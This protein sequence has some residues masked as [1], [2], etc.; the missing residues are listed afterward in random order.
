MSSSKLAKHIVSPYL[1]V[2]GGI[3]KI[4]SFSC[5][6]WRICLSIFT[7]AVSYTPYDHCTIDLCGFRCFEKKNGLCC[8]TTSEYSAQFC[9]AVCFMAIK[10]HQVFKALVLLQII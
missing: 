10:L 3:V 1:I 2:G 9:F 6:Y 8:C 5:V 7:I 4:V